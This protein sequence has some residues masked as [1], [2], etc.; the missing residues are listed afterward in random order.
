MRGIKSGWYAVEDD[1]GKLSSGPFSS[2]E[3]CVASIAQ[4]TNGT[5]ASSCSGGIEVHSSLLNVV[6]HDPR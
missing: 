4:P 5:M 3:A 2:L 6:L 1:D